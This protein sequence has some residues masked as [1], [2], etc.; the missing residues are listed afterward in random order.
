MSVDVSMRASVGCLRE[1]MQLRVNGSCMPL[2]CMVVPQCVSCSWSGWNGIILNS[3]CM[4]A[5]ALQSIVLRPGGAMGRLQVSSFK[6]AC[7]CIL[8]GDVLKF[9]RTILNCSMYCGAI[10]HL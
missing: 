5:A 1:C 3:R 8:E 2:K 10:V 4:K 6:S 7:R 9:D